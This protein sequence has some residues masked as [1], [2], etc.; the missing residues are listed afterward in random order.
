MKNN[1]RTLLEQAKTSKEVV[2]VYTDRCAPTKSSVGFVYEVGKDILIMKSLAPNGGADG[3]I[4]RKLKDIFKLEIGGVYAQK[5]KSLHTFRATK[6]SEDVPRR[7]NTQ[8]SLLENS[9]VK[10]SV[11]SIW[12]AMESDESYFSGFVQAVNGDFAVV[13]KLDDYGRSDGLIAF[14]VEDVIALDIDGLTE[15]RLNFLHKRLT[16]DYSWPKLL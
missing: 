12:L 15:Q 3:N 1:F 7:C 2:A 14:L 8:K 16:Y 10:E 9:M 11:V 5:L 6:T 13:R 4:T